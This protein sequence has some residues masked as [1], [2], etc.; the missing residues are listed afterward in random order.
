MSGSNDRSKCFCQLSAARAFVSSSSRS[1]VLGMP[2]AM[3]A[4]CAAILYAIQPCL[5]SSFFGSP[6]CSLGVT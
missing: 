4:E 6:R 5:T 1:R 2:S 3:S